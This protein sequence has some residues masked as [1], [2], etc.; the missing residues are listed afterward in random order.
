MV[1]LLQAQ[2]AV[3]LFQQRSLSGGRGGIQRL[4]LTLWKVIL[5]NSLRVWKVVTIGTEKTKYIDSIQ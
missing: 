4:Y 2:R 3:K 5:R 1:A